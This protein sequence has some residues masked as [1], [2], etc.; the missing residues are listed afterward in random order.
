MSIDR[1]E[2]FPRTRKALFCLFREINRRCIRDP[3]IYFSY[4]NGRRTCSPDPEVEQNARTPKRVF[5]HRGQRNGWEWIT[6]ILVIDLSR[7]ANFHQEKKKKTIIEI[8]PYVSRSIFIASFYLLSR[9]INRE[10]KR[11]RRI[12]ET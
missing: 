9:A 3:A 4:R 6:L 5:S 10:S 2:S 12:S 11:N 1:Y 7:D 8:F